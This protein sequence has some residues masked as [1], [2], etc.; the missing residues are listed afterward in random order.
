MKQLEIYSIR[1]KLEDFIGD[2]EQEK[3]ILE[4]LRFCK[5]VVGKLFTTIFKHNNLN[6]KEIKEFVKRNQTMLFDLGIEITSEDKFSWFTIDDNKIKKINWR[7]KWDGSI[8]EGLVEYKKLVKHIKG[9][10]I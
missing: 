8:L 9:K 7:Y 10:R 4:N 5:N 1:I 3:L 6:E 2:I